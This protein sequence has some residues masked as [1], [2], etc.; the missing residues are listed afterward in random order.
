MELKRGMGALRDLKQKSGGGGGNNMRF[1]LD[2]KQTAIVRFFGDFENQNDP[3]V[4]Q[5]HYIRRFGGADAYQYCSGVQ[6]CYCYGRDKGRDKGIGGAG[7]IA[8]LYVKDYR[9]QHKLD[10]P[11]RLLKPGIVARPGQTL[12]PEDYYE[13][14]YPPCS[15]P[16][17]PCQWCKQGLQSAYSGYRSWELSTSFAEQLITLQSSIRDF[18]HCGAKEEETG[19]GTIYV[20]SYLCGNAQ[21]GQIVDFDP[22]SGKPVASCAH[23][24]HT[25]QPLE[26]IACTACGEAASRT[27]LQDWLFKVSRNGEGTDT[28]Y[29]FEAFKYQPPTQEEL[30]EAAKYKPDWEKL[31]QPE[32]CEQQAARLGIANP[33]PPTPGHG[34]VAYNQPPAQAAPTPA[35][36]VQVQRPIASAPAPVPTK[37]PTFVLRRPGA[38]PAPV[39]TPFDDPAASDE[40]QDIRY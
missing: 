37:P 19:V 13:T 16:N 39:Q 7:G 33:F 25:T 2:D 3:P 10:A 34:A 11:V 8:G 12:R 36:R 30:D 29:N 23:C 21:C 40:D 26:Q 15:G 5:R 20:A 1:R 22:A 17:R 32:A 9:K 38:K 31:W 4:T 14:K 6:C 27:D 18:C 35:P 28:T 24:R